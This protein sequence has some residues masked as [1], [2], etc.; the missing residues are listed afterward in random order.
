[1]SLRDGRERWIPALKGRPIIEKAL[2]A[3]G[4]GVECRRLKS[5]H[6]LRNLQMQLGIFP[7]F[8]AALAVACGAVEV[9]AFLLIDEDL[10]L[11]SDEEMLTFFAETQFV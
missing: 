6:S 2:R 11:P 10:D 7:M 3:S 4:G 5:I 1:M 8:P 9:I